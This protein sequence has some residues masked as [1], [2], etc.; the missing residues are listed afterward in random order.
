MNKIILLCCFS[1]L[2]FFACTNSTPDAPFNEN[3]EKAVLVKTCDSAYAAYLAGDLM[4]FFSFL[5]DDGLFCGTDPGEFWNKSTYTE[6]I[7]KM[8][9]DTSFHS[10]IKLERREVHFES[11]GQS[12]IVVDQFHTGWSKNIPVRHV[13]HYV[14]KDNRWICDFSSMAM[15]PF[16]KDLDKI[17]LAVE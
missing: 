1:A 14:K 5:S 16:N 11:T 6:T 4:T 17:N 13:N 7:T 3:A 10:E 9:E 12:A 8:F 15:I 2:L